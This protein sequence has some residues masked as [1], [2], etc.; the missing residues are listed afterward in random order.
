MELFCSFDGLPF[1]GCSAEEFAERS[2]R[3]Q[4]QFAP[5]RDYRTIPK[6]GIILADNRTQDFLTAPAEEIEI[7]RQ[8]AIHLCDER[9]ALPEPILGALDFESHQCAKGR[10]VAAASD[11]V[12]VDRES[13]KVFEREI[14]SSLGV[15]GSYVLPEVGELQGGA[16][17]I[18]KALALGVAVA[19]EVENEMA[20]RIRG[21]AAVGEY[22]VESFEAGNC[23][24]LA[25][26]DQQV[27]EFVLR[28]VEFADGFG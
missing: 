15:V 1:T 11:V 22:V 9:Q 28:N 10:R 25:K 21:V 18:G 2:P 16:G 4:S 7:N 3:H 26:G 14:D 20:D 27:G 17:E 13:A 24:V 5:F 19:A 12:F 8:F 23:L 6:D